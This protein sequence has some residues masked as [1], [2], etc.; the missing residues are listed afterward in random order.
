MT[1]GPL[2]LIGLDALDLGEVRTRVADGRMPNL[3]RIVGV[4]S[5]ETLEPCVPGFAGA[6]WRSFVNAA[7]VGDHGWH[8][9]KVWRPEACR[10]D[11]ADPGFLRLEPFWNALAAAGLRLGLV[12]VPYAPDPGETFDGVFISGWQTHD[13]HP[14]VARPARLLAELHG[15]FGTPALGAEHYG[16][17][18]AE[19]LVHLHH[20]ALR[21]ID[22]IAGIGAHL[23]AH[24][25]FD[26]FALVIGAP[27][28]AGH[29]LWDLSQIDVRQLPPAE[30]STLHTAMDAVYDACDLAVGHL[31][32][33]APPGARVCIFALHGMGPNPGWTDIFPEI[34]RH[35]ARGP[36]RPGLRDRLTAWRRSQAALAAARLVPAGAQR[37]VRNVW[38][39]RMHDWSRTRY[40]S[41]P[42]EDGGAVRINLAGR[43]RE[44]IVGADDEYARLCSELA[45]RLAEVEDLETGRPIV[46][47]ARI[48]DEMVGV[49]APY[50]HYL[51]DIVVEWADRR[52][53]DS[54][55]VRFGGGGGELHW[56]RGR[57][58]TSG[59]SGN[60]RPQGW[61]AGE[62]SRPMP[63]SR[64]RSAV[65]L[66]GA[67]LGWFGVERRRDRSPVAFGL[68]LG[69]SQL[70]HG[71][72][73]L[74]AGL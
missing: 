50:R 51:P 42:R 17:P 12:D 47:Q 53:G 49:G 18:S 35:L 27:H 34:V 72:A 24:D 2:V 58:L 55:G 25:T 73:P 54:V 11:A 40:F 29:Y 70:L 21:S 38:S 59:R 7:P 15:R 28:R 22:Q 74:T 41:L 1:A 32:A 43:E 37:L 61:L 19:R 52:L 3:A 65:D 33:A 5:L 48:V 4:A 6:T 71:V 26:L 68:G 60:H 30:A 44:G 64:R 66:A 45:E 69:L 20:G 56:P 39:S 63:P 23:L 57:R 13:S 8:F 14:L 16:A 31:A 62:L 46:A 67:M 10:I 9:G 36:S